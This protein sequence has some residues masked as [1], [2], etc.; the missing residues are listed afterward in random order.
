MTEEEA[1]DKL[2]ELLNEIEVAGHEVRWTI[3][4]GTEGLEVGSGPF[5][6]EPPCEGEPWEV[7]L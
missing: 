5:I 2:C 3:Q 4:Y 6:A 7:R 1:A